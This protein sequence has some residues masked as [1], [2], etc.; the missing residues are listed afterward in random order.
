MIFS[1]QLNDLPTESRQPFQ[2]DWS[3]PASLLEAASDDDGLIDDL[4]EA[5]S[6]DSEDRIRLMRKALATPNS[7]PN[8]PPNFA[9]VR[10]EA[11]TIKGS[12]RQLGAG[13]LAEACEDLEM[14]PGDERLIAAR[15]NRVEELFAEVCGAMT[16]YSNSR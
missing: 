1:P 6:T 9:K 3:P 10:F 15:L 16:S 12:A 14:L 2:Q 5:F 7:P 11:H 4:I 8:S 13:A